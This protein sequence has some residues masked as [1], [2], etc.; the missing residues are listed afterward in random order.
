MTQQNKHE[1]TEA[2]PEGLEM[3]DQGASYGSSYTET[4]PG[5]VEANRQTSLEQPDEQSDPD[6]GSTDR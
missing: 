2:E 4:T 5:Q 3:G 1:R 6:R